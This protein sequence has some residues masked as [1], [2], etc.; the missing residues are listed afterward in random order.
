MGIIKG[1]DF[2]TAILKIWIGNE[3][4]DSNLKKA[5]PGTS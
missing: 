5:M 3:P 1:D 2:F 4:A